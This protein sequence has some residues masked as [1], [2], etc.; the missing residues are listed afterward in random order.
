MN[1]C[2]DI[3]EQTTKSMLQLDKTLSKVVDKLAG[4]DW[5][6]PTELGIYAVNIIG[7]TD[8]IT[9]VNNFLLWYF[10]E[11]SYFHAKKMLGEM[12]S[13]PIGEGIKNLINECWFAFE[14]KKYL[15]CANSLVVAIE[16]ILSMFWEDKKNIRM[17]QVCQAKVTES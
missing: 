10:S 9:D 12:L 14:N 1:L 4:E 17:M 8:E 11:K 15:I 2:S 7:D 16:G 5:T 6:L 13:V 3:K